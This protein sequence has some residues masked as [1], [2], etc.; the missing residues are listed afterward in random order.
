MRF[1]HNVV[2]KSDTGVDF[3]IDYEELHKV[4]MLPQRVWYS[5]VISTFITES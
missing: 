4:H 1:Y 2:S 5:D 3:V